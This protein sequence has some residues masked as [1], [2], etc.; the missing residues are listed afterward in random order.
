MK[1]NLPSHPLPP[2]IQDLSTPL[3]SCKRPLNYLKFKKIGKWVT[4]LLK[5]HIHFFDLVNSEY[6]K[7]FRPRPGINSC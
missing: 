7:L 4:I 3:Y 6:L 5:L 2:I 1:T